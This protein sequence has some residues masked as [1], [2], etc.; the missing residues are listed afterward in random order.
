MTL[1]S[2][3]AGYQHKL[4]RIFFW[5]IHTHMCACVCE[6]TCD[7][8]VVGTIIGTIKTI[9]YARLLVDLIPLLSIYFKTIIPRSNLLRMFNHFYIRVLY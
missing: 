7:V 2:F 1:R 4:H 8:Y 9:R 6:R 3:E 5:N